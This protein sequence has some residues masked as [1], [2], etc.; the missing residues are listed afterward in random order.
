M[1]LNGLLPCGLAAP[2]TIAHSFDGDKGPGMAVCETGVTHCGLPE[3]S[4]AVNGKV[5]VQVTWQNVRVYDYNGKLLQTTPMTTFIRNAGLN[6]I[7]TEHRK[8]VAPSAPGPFELHVVYDEFIDRWIVTVTGQNDCMIV[9]TSS[10]PTGSWGGVYPS[11]LQGGPCLDYDPAVH[12]GYDKNGVYYCGGHLGDDNPNTIPKVAYDCFAMPP[13][14]VKEIARRT[15]P[16]HVNRA[17]NMPLD[18]MP[19][20]DHN[21]SKAAS[22]PAFFA[23]KTCGREMMGACQNSTGFTFE[24]VIDTFTWKGESGTYNIGGEQLVK[25][26]AGSKQDKWQ[27]NKPCCG[28]SASIP[29]AGNDTM[30]LR[31]AESHRLANLAQFGSHLYGAMGSG[32]CT[33]SCGSQG[34]DTNN[35]VFWFDMDCS[36]TTACVVVQ[37]SKI[38]GADFNPEFAT[39]GVDQAGNIGIAASSSTSTTDLSV[40]LWTRRKS[41][42]PG[43]FTG[44]T[45]VVAGTQPYT[46]LNAKN[47]NVIGNAAGVLTALDPSDGT[48]LWTSQQWS[49]DAARCAWNTRI[50]G[51]RIG[52]GK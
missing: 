47:I 18:I 46:C 34:T 1:A 24:W 15:P 26:D 32:P 35:V 52:K 7:P 3:M 27:Y 50:V 43:A 23:A 25:T 28:E 33:A 16:A 51:Y 14:E 6:P 40:L 37:T 45:T 11:C 21:R 5:A 30:T 48:T 20:V 13:N 22:A 42:P 36:K 19:S 39:V 38:S 8:P 44:P 41:D 31:V 29:Q 9:S 2:P 10:D 17:H 49:N 4:V 12:I